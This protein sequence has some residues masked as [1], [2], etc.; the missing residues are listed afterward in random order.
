MSHRGG[1]LVVVVHPGTAV[2]AVRHFEV[3][4]RGEFELPVQRGDVFLPAAKKLDQSRDVLRHEMSVDRRVGLAV[5]LARKRAPF[6]DR[7]KFLQPR[8]ILIAR[9]HEF[10]GGIPEIGVVVCAIPQPARVVGLVQGL[11][12]LGQTPILVGVFERHGGAVLVHPGAFNVLGHIAALDVIFHSSAQ[13][14][15]GVF[16]ACV[17]TNAAGQGVLAQ[18]GIGK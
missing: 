18:A 6:A 17:I 9:A 16:I 3:G 12:E 4:G 15:A 1:R 10:H 5:T 14:M 11:G 7:C 8:A 13:R 2:F